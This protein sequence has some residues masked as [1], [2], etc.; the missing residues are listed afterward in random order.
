MSKLA[1]RQTN[2]IQWRTCLL[3]GFVAVSTLLPLAV[4]ARAATLEV[5][6]AHP[7]A[8]RRATASTAF[9]TVETSDHARLMAPF[10]GV[11]KSVSV[12]AGNTVG[13]GRVL[14]RIQPLTLASR[15]RAAAA[16]VAAAKA[17]LAQNKILAAQRLATAAAMETARARLAARVAALAALQAQLRLG[18]VRAPF[19]GTVRGLAA[20]GSRVLQGQQLLHI[21]GNGGLRIEAEF[22]LAAV[23]GLRAGT[24]MAISA[25]GDSAPGRVY[26]VAQAADRYGLVSVYL[27]PPPTLRLMPGEVVQVRLDAAA[28]GAW[29]VP[30][31][32][33][34]LRGTSA[35]VFL[36]RDGRARA[37][38]VKLLAVA[39]DGAVVLGDLRPDSRVI[40]S[41]VAWLRDG[42]PATLK[43]AEPKP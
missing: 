22:P 33:V 12:R 28:E 15:T 37:L 9:G 26:S 41:D 27:A 38:T 10:D 21:D 35:R 34:V 13:A 8:S 32:A 29:R 5:S 2:R 20:V 16:A 4:N 1:I 43:P 31:A 40:V 6:V 17:D 19:A 3:S 42:V 39:A 14:L 7:I 25:D 36:H 23:R 18:I 30:Q 24:A 11:V